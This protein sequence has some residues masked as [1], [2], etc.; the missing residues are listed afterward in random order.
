[1]DLYLTINDDPADN[2]YTKILKIRNILKQYVQIKN[3]N[4]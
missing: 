4:K 3:M 1:M 2:F